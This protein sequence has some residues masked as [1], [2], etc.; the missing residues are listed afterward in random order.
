MPGIAPGP[1][2]SPGVSSDTAPALDLLGLLARRPTSATDANIVATP[3]DYGGIVVARLLGLLDSGRVPLVALPEQ[4]GE[5]GLR[6]RSIVDLHHDHIGRPVLVMFEQAD[7]SRP[8][9]MGVL[10]QDDDVP[11]APAPLEVRYDG[12]RV[13]IEADTELVLRCGLSHITLRRDGQVEVRGETILTRASGPN[14]LQGGSV[15]LN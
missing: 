11:A 1:L 9:V 8:I 7:R 3:I 4:P 12:G 6:A 15:Q 14:K 10:R 2:A 13:L 5:P